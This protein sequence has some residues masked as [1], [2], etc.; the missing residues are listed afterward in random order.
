MKTKNTKSKKSKR[1][2]VAPDTWPNRREVGEQIDKSE[3]TI[4]RLAEAG[5]L[6]ALPD[7]KGAF[8]VDPS[9]LER[10]VAQRAPDSAPNRRSAGPTSE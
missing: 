5:A 1:K 3:R 9:G 10:F 2:K 8:R 6:H 7:K 4:R